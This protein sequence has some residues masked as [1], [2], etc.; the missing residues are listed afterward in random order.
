[1]KE[2]NAIS[3]ELDKRK[4]FRIELVSAAARGEKNGQ[5]EVKVKVLDVD[6]EA[7]WL[8]SRNRFLNRKYVMQEMY[9]AKMD[10]QPD[11]D[12]EQDADPFFEPLDAE[13]RIG[14]VNLWLK[15]LAYMVEIEHSL[16]ITDYRGQQL[17]QSCGV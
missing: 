6:T 7:S 16:N 9:H 13:L 14:F 4:F 10:D 2:A 15:S 3:E 11:W 1:M 17:G 12:R 8:W 5:T